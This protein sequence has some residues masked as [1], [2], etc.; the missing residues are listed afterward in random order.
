MT[1][2]SNEHSRNGSKM[3]KRASVDSAATG[4][5]PQSQLSV[6]R[7]ANVNKRSVGKKEDIKNELTVPD[8]D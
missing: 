7:T 3:Q 5:K 1:L 8:H 4:D 2:N 6:Q